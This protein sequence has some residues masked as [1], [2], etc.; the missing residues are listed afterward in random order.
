MGTPPLV[1]RCSP[2]S[3]AAVG[4]PPNGAD[5]LTTN[6]LN[7][8]GIE[9][10]IRQFF[11]EYAADLRQQHR[12]A[13]ADGYD[14]RGAFLLGHGMKGFED[15]ASIRKRHRSNWTGP[16]PFKWKVSITKLTLKRA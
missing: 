2:R 9:K 3:L 12:D 1:H 11:D 15:L 13:I 10:E 4:K 5:A 6:A 8:T 14:S 7:T 16:K